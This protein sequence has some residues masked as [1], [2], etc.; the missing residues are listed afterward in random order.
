MKLLMIYKSEPDQSTAF[1][2]AKL[3]EGK[4]VA[5]FNLY[6]DT[7]YDKLVGVIFENDEII[8]WW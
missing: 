8:S 4:D 3:S 7:D 6:E 2:A 1:L 5:R